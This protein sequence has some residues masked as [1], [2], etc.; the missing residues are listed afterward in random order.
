MNCPQCSAAN[1]PDAGFCASC[2]TRLAVAEP[3]APA[4][5]Y[6]SEAAG[7]PLGYNAPSGYGAPTGY[8]APSGGGYNAPGGY[9]PPSGYNAN[10]P[11]QPAGYQ[12]GQYPPPGQYQP[13]AQPGGWQAPGSGSPRGSGSIPP[14]NFDLNRATTVDKVVAVATFITMIS[15]WMTWFTVSYS[16]GGLGGA[17]SASASATT[18]HGA[19]MYLEFL[20]ALVL[21]VYLVARVAW[22][23]LPISVPIA[24]A[25]V[26]IVGTALQLIFVLIAFFDIPSLP[27]GF[28]V[29]WGFGAFLGLIGALVAAGPV[30]Y[31]AGRSYLESRK[32][33]TG[34]PGSY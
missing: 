25:P 9:P 1:G 17:G 29:G 6:G 4:G 14:V 20:V 23:T 28:S 7:T 27:A 3:A 18:A 12:Q 24:H 5:G 26:L 2:G 33:N 32:G 31:P 10:G 34:G 15:I 13:P 16:G 22:E 11:S 8:D 30:L 21:I 19:W